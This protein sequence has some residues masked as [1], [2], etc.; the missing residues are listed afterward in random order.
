MGNIQPIN[1]EEFYNDN[2]VD[3]KTKKKQLKGEEVKLKKDGETPKNI[4]NSQKRGGEVFP[5]R[6]KEDIE[7]IINYFTDKMNN[8]NTQ[9]HKCIA[10]RYRLL[11]VLGFNTACRCGDILDLTWG[12]I[13]NKQGEF[14]DWSRIQ[15]EKTEKY[16]NLYFNKAI[17]NYISEYISVFNPSLNPK[18]YIFTSREGGKIQVQTALR[19]IKE[20]AEACNVRVNVGTHTMR[21]TFGYWFIK[22]HNGDM[23]AILHLQKILNHSSLMTTLRYCGLDQDEL[24]IYY[25][26]MNIG[27]FEDNED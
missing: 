15:E 17:K 13:F 24:E 26:N 27:L 1:E 19:A 18:G 2:L 3:F 23:R 9:D 20:A 22:K 10:A 4:F 16:R 21:K 5:L 8:A 14:I 11:L 12:D 25:N 6:K 7:A